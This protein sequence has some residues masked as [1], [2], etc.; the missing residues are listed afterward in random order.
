MKIN[1]YEDSIL[2]AARP[3]D[4]PPPAVAAFLDML[5]KRLANIRSK[6]EVVV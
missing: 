6:Y 1:S 5:R 4:H 2:E 3:D